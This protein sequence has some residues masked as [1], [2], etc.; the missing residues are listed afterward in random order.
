LSAQGVVLDPFAGSGSSLIAAQQPAASTSASRRTALPHGDNTPA[1]CANLGRM[2]DN[3]GGLHGPPFC[4][5][6]TLICGAFD[7]TGGQWQT[8][9][10]TF[11]AAAL[12]QQEIARLGDAIVP[13]LDA[14]RRMTPQTFRALIADMLHRFGHEIVTDPITPDLI[15]AKAGKKFITQCAAPTEWRLAAIRQLA[16]LHDA[17]IAANAARGFF[18][19]LHG[20]THGAAQY[21][22]CAPLDLFDGKRL[23][24]ALHQ[25]RKHVLMPQTYAMCRQS[26]EIVQ[27]RLDRE[28][29]EARPCGNGHLVAPTIA[30]AILVPPRPPANAAGT[31]KAPAPRPPS[32]GEI[33][34]HNRRYEA[35]MMKKPL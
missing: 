18:I 31:T 1:A 8:N 25:S 35:R 26:G 2:T 24:K 14:M 33:N 34:A 7:S 9:A 23:V 3:R 12:R 22:A 21:A 20:F 30:R 32:R 19:T 27:H 13:R 10:M 29:D 17:V 16:G 5:H 6:N 28:Q 11:A 4:S 15:T